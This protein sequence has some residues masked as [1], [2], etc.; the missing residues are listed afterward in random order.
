MPLVKETGCGERARLR[1]S[2]EVPTNLFL[3]LYAL[4][5]IKKI[6]CEFLYFYEMF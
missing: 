3:L 1:E 2:K 4:V 5:K 6:G